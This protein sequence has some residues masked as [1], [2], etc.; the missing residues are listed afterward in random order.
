MALRITVSSALTLPSTHFPGTRKA[1]FS[2]VNQNM[3]LCAAPRQILCHFSSFVTETFAFGTSL[4]RPSTGTR[5]RRGSD[6][7][8]FKLSWAMPRA[9]TLFE[10]LSGRPCCAQLLPRDGDEE[11]CLLA[12]VLQY[13]LAPRAL[14]ASSGNWCL[15]NCVTPEV[16]PSRA[17][18]GR[19]PAPWCPPCA[20]ASQPNSS[21]LHPSGRNCGRSSAE[22][23]SPFSASDLLHV[24]TGGVEGAIS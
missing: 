13:G 17:T 14:L 3:L 24:P 15:E 16:G 22:T 12:T 18:G 7:Y 5:Q 1:S 21:V 20:L 23:T 11:F 2:A 6:K 8:S 9:Y 19:G 4:G 10:D